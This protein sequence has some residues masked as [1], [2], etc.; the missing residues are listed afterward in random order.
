MAM[1]MEERK[2]RLLQLQPGGVLDGRDDGLGLEVVAEAVDALLPANAAH[3][4]AAERDGRVEHVVGVHPH[5]P[6]PQCPRQGVRRVQ[7]LG[8]HPRRQPVWRRVR[9]P[10]HL[11]HRAAHCT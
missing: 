10:H 11:L 7:P 3:L 8:E 9:P 4:V 1:G 2:D 5:R 6:D